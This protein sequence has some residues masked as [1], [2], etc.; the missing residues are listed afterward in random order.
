MRASSGPEQ[1]RHTAPP[2]A[3]MKAT[4]AAPSLG[5]S[6]PQSA[7]RDFREGRLEVIVATTQG[8]PGDASYTLPVLI[9]ETAFVNFQL[10]DAA[11]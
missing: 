8:G 7:Q 11:V 9:W 5:R 6:A 2:C 4:R 1:L 10:G 3:G